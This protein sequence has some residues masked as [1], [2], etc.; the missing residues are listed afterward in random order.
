MTKKYLIVFQK[1]NQEWKVKAL[2]NTPY[3]VNEFRTNGDINR[4]KRMAR[5]Y[6]NQ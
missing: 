4:M 1:I 5:A 2:Q 6:E 3:A